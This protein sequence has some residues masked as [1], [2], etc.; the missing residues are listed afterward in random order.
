MAFTFPRTCEALR[1]HGIDPDTVL[2]NGTNEDGY[3]TLERHQDGT[4]LPTEGGFDLYRVPWPSRDV[5]FKVREALTL[6]T[7]ANGGAPDP[8]LAD[9]IEAAADWLEARRD[10]T[11]NGGERR[12]SNF[13]RAAAELRIHAAELRQADRG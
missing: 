4:I 1:A 9:G 11:W 13:G 6:D 3:L 5:W 10:P 8:R 7:V 2:A 12:P